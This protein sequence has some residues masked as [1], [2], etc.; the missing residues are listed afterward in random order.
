MLSEIEATRL[1]DWRYEIC[2]SNSKQS[3]IY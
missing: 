2:S 3:N 1:G